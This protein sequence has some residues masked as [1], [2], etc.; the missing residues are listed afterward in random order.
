MTRLYCIRHGKTQWNLEGRY[1]GSHGDSP[2]LPESYQDI[3]SLG[4][5]LKNQHLKFK[6]IYASPLLRTQTTAVFLNLALGKEL[7]IYLTDNFREF[8]LGVMEGKT[9][10]EMEQKFPDE[11][12]AFRHQPEHYHAEVIRGESFAEVIL[13]THQ[14]IEAIVQRYP[15]PD[16]NVLIVSHGA[17]LVAMMQSLLGTPISFIRKDG[18]L[19]NT[20]LTILETLDQGHSYH[21]IVWNETSFLH[22][23][24]QAS[25][26]I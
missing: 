13:R 24:L 6:A 20:S 12:S 22:K 11:V 2:L 23:T 16:D 10:K 3:M 8:D 14:E 21:K 5:H 17:A 9:F 1:Q 25:D 7:P 4:Q 19:T 15:R 18:G 26:S